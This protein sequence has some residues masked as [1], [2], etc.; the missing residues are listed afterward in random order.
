MQ[1]NRLID[2][3]KALADPTRLRILILLSHSPLHGQ[4]IAGKLGLKPPTITHHMTKLREAGLVKERR[5]GNTIYFQLER[6]VL[7]QKSFAFCSLLKEEE[8]DM[9]KTK[10]TLRTEAIWRNF[11]TPDNRLKT[12]PAQRKKRIVVLHR[13]ASSFNHGQKYEEKE[14]NQIIQRFHDDFATLRRELII[15]QFMYREKGIYELNPAEMWPASEER[16][17]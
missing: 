7:E 13:I 15:H 9:S 10:G 1:L 5:E 11:F 16:E 6:R 4:A 8:T 3:H 2:F 12:I 14:I 17:I